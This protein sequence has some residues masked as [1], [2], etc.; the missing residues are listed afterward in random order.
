MVIVW[1]FTAQAFL[2]QLPQ[3]QKGAVEQAVSRL[4]HNFDKLKE[5]HLKA[6]TGFREREGEEK[7]YSFRV[8][9]DLTVILARYSGDVIEVVDIVRQS[10]IERLQ[11][12][13]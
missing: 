10:Q 7:Y 12:A 11:A 1:G 5:T 6:L 8:G 9:A 13:R 3:R 4:A 2:D